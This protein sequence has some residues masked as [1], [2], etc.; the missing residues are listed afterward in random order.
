M[1][2]TSGHD[3]SGVLG[4]PSALIGRDPEYSTATTFLAAA[5]SGPVALVLTG[6]VGIGKTAILRTLLVGSRRR[7][8]R[9]METRAVEAEAQLA[10]GGLADLLDRSVDEVL[11]R[12]PPAQR[13]A[14]EVA[15]QRIPAGEDPPP[16]LAVSLGTLA[17]IRALAERASVIVAVDDLAWLDRPSARVLECALRRLTGV[18]VGFVS[19]SG[20]TRVARRGAA[21]PGLPGPSTWRGP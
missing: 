6:P 21:P 3:A 4:A 9:T 15:L 18:R 7:G 16:P 12:L 1:A 20:P 17:V 5:A 10:F 19:T 14:L 2:P 13:V 8:Y 11:D